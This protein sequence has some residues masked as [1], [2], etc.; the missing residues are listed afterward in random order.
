MRKALLLGIAVGAMALSGCGRSAA[1]GGGPTVSRNY[2]VASFDRIEVAGPYNVQVR[3][4]ANP[5]ATAR[6]PEKM[7]DRLVVEVKDGKLLVH[8]QENRGFNFHWGSSHGSVEVTVTVPQL[9]GATIAGSGDIQVDH[10]RGDRFAGEVGGSGSLGL[11]SVEVK[12]LKLSIG[13]SG[14]IKAG[15]GTSQTAEYEIG[16]SGDIDAGGLTAQQ[17]K[18]SIAGSGSTKARATGTAEVNV[19]GSGDVE[20]SGGAKCSVDKAGSGDVRCS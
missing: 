8:S 2:P 7:I 9:S 20:I 19:M 16:G 12:T 5:S 1:E 13:G 14:D 15:G 11:G 10:V 17:A 4:G 3:T 18:V 6:G